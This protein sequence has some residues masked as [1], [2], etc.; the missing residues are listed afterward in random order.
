MK[1]EAPLKMQWAQK[2]SDEKR[3]TPKNQGVQKNSNKKRG[4]PKKIKGLK[5][6][7]MKK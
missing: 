1:K 5:R 7:P 3:G 2:T 6:A 4:T